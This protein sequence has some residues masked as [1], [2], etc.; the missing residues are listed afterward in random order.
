LPDF[1]EPTLPEETIIIR[2]YDEDETNK[3]KKNKNKKKNTTKK[4]KKNVDYKDN[5]HTRTMDDN[6]SVY[7]QYN[8]KQDFDIEL[9]GETEVTNSFIT[10]CLHKN[11]TNRMMRIR[12]VLIRKEVEELKI[13][14]KNREYV[15]EAGIFKKVKSLYKKPKSY[16]QR[17]NSD[18]M[19]QDNVIKYDFL[20]HIE[21]MTDYNKTGASIAIPDYD[22]NYK[23]QV[24]E[25][26]QVFSEKESYGLDVAIID[27]DLNNETTNQLSKLPPVSSKW[28]D[29]GVSIDLPIYDPIFDT[30]GKSYIPNQ[31]VK[32]H[33][34]DF[35]H[36]SNHIDNDTAVDTIPDILLED[37]VT[38]TKTCNV[39]K[40]LIFIAKLY[41]KNC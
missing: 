21:E 19:H 41:L 9:D 22:S 6:L 4:K 32:S 27:Y 15:Y 23:N 18:S 7:N 29:T 8:D 17:K 5:I 26:D 14:L 13:G 33:I 2:E 20:K 11:I 3:S 34:Y 25:T 10:E 24:S 39:L 30:D 38:N 36:I 28:T 16:I 12:K 35:T 37:G 31:R 1:Y 40:K